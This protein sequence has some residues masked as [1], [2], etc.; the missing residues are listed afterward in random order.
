MK[1]K[2]FPSTF[3][4]SPQTVTVDNIVYEIRND[5]TAQLQNGKSATGDVV[6]PAEVEYDGKKYS[7]YKINSDAFENN[8]AI[9]SVEMPASLKRIDRF[10][11]EGCRSL[12]S[13]TGGAETLDWIGQRPFWQTPWLAN[14]PAEDGLKYWKGW[15]VDVSQS[16]EFDELH[17]KEG[18][19]GKILDF[20]YLQGKT[21]YLPKSFCEFKKDEIRVERFVVDKEHPKWF[22]DDYGA[23]YEKNCDVSYYSYNKNTYLDATGQSLYLAPTR[24]SGGTL[25]VAEGTVV[26]VEGSCMNGK[27]DRIIVPEGCEYVLDNSLRQLSICKYIELPSTL[28][29]FCMFAPDGDSQLEIVL[30][31]KEVP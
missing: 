6:I 13:I 16:N 24:K 2:N 31:A 8:G 22:S 19:I 4:L 23:I 7:V 1:Q 11:F 25:M 28:K 20:E 17:I 21:L 10:A 30:K 12:A 14:L 29:Y 26:L 5:G 27:F 9:T 3:P 18:T 15:I